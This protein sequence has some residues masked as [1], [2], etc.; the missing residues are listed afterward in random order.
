VAYVIGEGRWIPRRA[1]VLHPP[2]DPVFSETGHW[3]STCIACHAT[4]G[5]PEF[6]TPFGS[7]P[8]QRQ[9]VQTRAAEFGIACEACHGPGEEHARLNRSPLRR[10]SLHL[11]ERPD[12][13]MVLPTRLN[14]RLSS[15]VCGQCHGV[16]EFYDQQGERLANSAGLP[17]KPGDQ[18]TS[19]RFMAQP[20]RNLEADT[21]KTLLAEDQ[22]FINDSFWSDGMIR[23]TG[24]VGTTASIESPCFKNAT[25]DQRSTVLRLLPTP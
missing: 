16:W 24:R 22:G 19:T 17:Y 18:L 7:R 1:A 25:D 14:P 12:P 10:Y 23:V 2:A 13:T 21:M 3:N 6:D 5:K 9:A 20:T 4:H 8:I 11:T 15:Q